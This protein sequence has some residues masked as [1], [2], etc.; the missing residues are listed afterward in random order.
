LKGLVTLI[1]LSPIFNRD[2]IYPLI[3][4]ASTVVI[5][6]FLSAHATP[7]QTP[8]PGQAKS[9]PSIQDNSF[10]IEEAY[11]Q[12]RGTVQHISLFAR[13]RD[14]GWQYSFTQEWAI[15]SQKHQF[16]YTLLVGHIVRS[17]SSSET[18]TET[19]IGDVALNYR[20][21]LV[22]DGNSRLAVAPRFSVELPAGDETR[23]LRAGGAG[24]QVNVPVSIVLHDKLITHLNA[25]TTYF[26]SARSRSRE[27]A[28]LHGYNLGESL[29][30]QVHK[31][32]NLMLESVY[33]RADFVAGEHRAGHEYLFV[34]NPG[35]RWAYNFASG[36]QIVPGV[37]LTFGIGPS[38]GERGLLL[39]LSFEHAFKKHKG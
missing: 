20:Y 8:S 29:I 12:E 7:A 19:A 14:G 4:L 10:L 15:F 38:R 24:I 34:L 35:F 36:L 17:N 30:W 22:G 2:A 37:A 27:E 16:S 28:S 6:A 25:G 39:Y 13:Q 18:E 31:R 1:T 33:A 5:A 21:Q 23:G 32:F 9:T 11:N 26:P 3:R